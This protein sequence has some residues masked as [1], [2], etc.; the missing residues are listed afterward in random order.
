MELRYFPR[1]GCVCS[2]F[3]CSRSCRWDRSRSWLISS[4]YSWRPSARLA[5]GPSYSREGH[6]QWCADAYRGTVVTHCDS[7]SK[8]ASP[9]LQRTAHVGRMAPEKTGNFRRLI[10][11]LQHGGL[12]ETASH[13]TDGSA[14]SP[15]C[16]SLR[17]EPSRPEAWTRRWRD[18]SRHYHKECEYRK[19]ITVPTLTSRKHLLRTPRALLSLYIYIQNHVGMCVSPAILGYG[20]FTRRGMSCAYIRV[21][22]SLVFDY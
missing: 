17:F 3:F 7:C 13:F 2:S 12:D 14:L 1:V 21:R 20:I 16:Q 6:P 10:S 11:L 4:P 9:L 8:F 5:G 22:R 19:S 15:S 18:M